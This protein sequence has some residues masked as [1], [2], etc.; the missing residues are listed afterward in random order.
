MTLEVI[1]N[2]C[3]FI[4]PWFCAPCCSRIWGQILQCFTVN[5]MGNCSASQSQGRRAQGSPCARLTYRLRSNHSRD[6][7]QWLTSQKTHPFSMEV[8]EDICFWVFGCVFFR[9]FNY[10]LCMWA[11]LKSLQC[12]LLP[13]LFIMRLCICSGKSKR[14]TFPFSPQNGPSRPSEKF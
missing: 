7:A 9:I 11:I 2:L 13:R 5:H 4:T 1:S 14:P 12:V 8:L 3:H 6:M 10:Q